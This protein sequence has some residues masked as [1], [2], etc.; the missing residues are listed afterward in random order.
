IHVGVRA[1]E[2]RLQRG[3]SVCG[4]RGQRRLRVRTGAIEF[5]SDKE[6]GA[7]TAVNQRL[8][9]FAKARQ[10]E[11]A[12]ERRRVDGLN[13]ERWMTARDDVRVAGLC[14]GDRIV[15]RRIN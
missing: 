14:A 4:R 11:R 1:A 5:I 12:A 10:V 3:A 8:A 9:A 7:I 2:E 13:A 15:A 6:E